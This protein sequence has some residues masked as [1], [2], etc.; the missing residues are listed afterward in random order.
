MVNQIYSQV[1]INDVLYLVSSVLCIETLNA[2]IEANMTLQF[3][4]LQI[5]V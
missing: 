2:K 3:Y 1:L 5:Y 4:I